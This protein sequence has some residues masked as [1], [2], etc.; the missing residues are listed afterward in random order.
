MIWGI[1]IIVVILL[2]SSPNVKGYLGEKTVSIRLNGLLM[3][4][5]HNSS[6]LIEID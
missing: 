3:E 2:L 4:I 6:F 1:I 5:I